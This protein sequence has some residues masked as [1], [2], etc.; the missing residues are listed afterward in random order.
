SQIPLV[1]TSS[2]SVVKRTPD[3][4]EQPRPS[5]HQSGPSPT[6]AHQSETSPMA[7]NQG[8]THPTLRANPFPE[9]TDLFCRLPLSTLFYQLEAD[10]QG[11]TGPNR[12]AE[13]YR[14]LN[15][16]SGQT[17]FRFICVAAESP[18]PGSGML[19]GFP[20][21]RRHEESFSLEYLLLPPRSA[22]EAVPPSIA[23]KASSP[24]STPAYSSARHKNADGERVPT[25]MATVLL[26][27]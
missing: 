15:P 3:A 17:D 19:T 22:L 7:S 27:R 4:R 8:P 9:V 10:C 2:K 25:S 26:S 11:R 14:P 12:S 6:V 18:H 1:R 16:S 21:D 13:L 24:T 20:F 23:A 5:T